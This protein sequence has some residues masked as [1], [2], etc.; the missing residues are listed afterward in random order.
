MDL[1]MNR[2]SSAVTILAVFLLQT[3]GSLADERHYLINRLLIMTFNMEF[4]C[5]SPDERR[6]WIRTN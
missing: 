1:I 5:V 2:A 6:I 4:L 3:C